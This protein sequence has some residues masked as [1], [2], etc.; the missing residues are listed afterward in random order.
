MH[1]P[2]AML[3]KLGAGHFALKA[4]RSPRRNRRST[5][6]RHIAV[7]A[8]SVVATSALARTDAAQTLFGPFYYSED[9]SPVEIFLGKWLGT[10]K[11]QGR[12]IVLP[13]AMI[14]F[15]GGYSRPTYLEIP[16]RI[17]T[18][19]LRLKLMHPDGRPMSI[20][21][22]ERALRTGESAPAVI[23]SLEFREATYSLMLG[24][25]I[26]NPEYERR[27]QVPQSVRPGGVHEDNKVGE[28]DGLDVYETSRVTEMFVPRDNT[29]EFFYISCP[30]KINLSQWCRYRF[31]LNEYIFATANF[32]SLRYFGGRNLANRR[33]RTLRQ[34][35]C[36]HFECELVDAS[37]HFT[38][39]ERGPSK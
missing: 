32:V 34:S 35:L 20:A 9:P 18:K 19:R 16:A 2:S 25:S 7:A 3:G 10:P 1:L 30:K 38:L 11:E 24:F 6:G 8:I 29:N 17:R 22:K 15:A 21:V 13:R 27:H 33:I 4:P 31:R 36:Q 12:T 23:N 14:N 39:Y 28:Y 5:I 26:V 37:G